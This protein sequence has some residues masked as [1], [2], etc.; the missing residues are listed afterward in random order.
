MLSRGARRFHRRGGEHQ[1]PRGRLRLLGFGLC[2]LVLAL[3]S[4]CSSPQEPQQERALNPQA[5]VEKVDGDALVLRSGI[6]NPVH[7]H[8]GDPLFGGDVVTTEVGGAAELSM[9][10]GYLL[11]VRSGSRV[12]INPL[13]MGDM[14][15]LSVLLQRGRVL[16]RAQAPQANSRLVL[17]T[18]SLTAN[19]KSTELEVGVSEDLGVLLCVRQGTLQVESAGERVSLAA[20]QESEVD[21]LE[22]PSAPR[23]FKEKTEADWASWMAARFR[24]LAWRM[25]E[26]V[27]KVD[28]CLRETASQRLEV[29]TELDRRIF[30]ME[31]LAR[32]LG[33][34]DQAL[35]SEQDRAVRKLQEL[36]L[37][38]AETLVLLRYLDNRTETLLLETERLQKRAQTMKRELGER[39]GP[40]EEFLRLLLQ[41]GK[42]LNR[43]L[44][45]ERSYLDG[46]AQRWRVA[47]AAAGGLPPPQVEKAVLKPGRPPSPAKKGSTGSLSK[48]AGKGKGTPPKSTGSKS[49]SKGATRSGGRSAKA[50]LGTTHSKTGTRKKPASSKKTSSGGSTPKKSSQGGSKKKT[51][52]AKSRAKP[53][54]S[55]P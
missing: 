4:G 14:E 22:R 51:T 50:N 5:K 11:S 8:I 10:E 36:A 48:R 21:F 30:E 27:A 3:V 13:L 46:Q 40:L 17:E 16:L 25:P 38:Q 54:G 19:V 9:G 33:E 26:L 44:Q 15:N 45:E 32:S 29:R 49:L 12:K 1:L 53:Q 42:P 43:A 2:F 28:R 24:N 6:R 23:S 18:A 47:V 34:T 31:S 55:S 35:G 41:C 39:Y 37:L 20:S 52:T 7:L